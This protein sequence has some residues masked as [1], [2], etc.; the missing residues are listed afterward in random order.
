M[1]RKVVF[2]RSHHMGIQLVR[3]VIT[4][5]AATVA[6]YAVLILLVRYAGYAETI[7]GMVSMC[8]GLAVVYVLGRSWVFPHIPKGYRRIEFILFLLIAGAGAVWHI[9]ILRYAVLGAEIHYLAAKTAAMMVTF[10]WNFG[11]RRITASVIIQRALII[12]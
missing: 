8:A 5:G 1:M 2:G 9:A 7:S 12:I 3:S 10:L 6:D 4:S 11:M